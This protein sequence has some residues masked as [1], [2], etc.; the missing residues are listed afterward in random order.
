MHSFIVHGTTQEK[1]HKRLLKLI[2]NLTNLKTGK[3]Q[4]VFDLEDPDILTLIP[5]PSI[6]INNV[7]KLKKFLSFKPYSKPKKIGLILSA[8][9]LTLQA[10]NALLKTLEEPS[11]H[12]LLLLELTNPNKL[13]T[14][15]LSRCQLIEVKQSPPLINTPRSEP[16][17]KLIK[18][19]TRSS[20]GS[21]LNLVKNISSQEETRKLLQQML[22]RLKQNLNKD[23][24]TQKQLAL[25]H[26]SLT[27]LDSNINTRLVLEH[28]ALYF[29][30]E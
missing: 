19:L 18:E 7:R 29:K 12:S 26:D 8:D 2:T 11:K 13:L 28:L 16:S 1:R 14:T 21:R 3:L 27:A 6:G 22:Q 24:K 20:P 9:K 5:H 15:V 30:R 17:L 4:S 25:V 10:Q 23:P